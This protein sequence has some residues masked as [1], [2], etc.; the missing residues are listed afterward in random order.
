MILFSTNILRK[1]SK[2]SFLT[3]DEEKVFFRREKLQRVCRGGGGGGGPHLLVHKVQ[4]L[5]CLYSH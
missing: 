2:E 3:K 1:E 5:D 4:I